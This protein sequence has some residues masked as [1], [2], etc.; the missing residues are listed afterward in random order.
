MFQSRND[1]I[2]RLESKVQA[3][4]KGHQVDEKIELLELLIPAEMAAVESLHRVC[5]VG[6]KAGD[7]SVLAK[8]KEL[9]QLT[10]DDDTQWAERLERLRERC[11]RLQ[12][13]T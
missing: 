11:A 2:D 3:L 13:R 12:K 7:A 5:G 8:L 1:K 4:T 9:R 6:R 10:R